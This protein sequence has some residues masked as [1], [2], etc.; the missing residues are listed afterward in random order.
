MVKRG[1]DEQR[2]EEEEDNGTDCREVWSS[3]G[4]GDGVFLPRLSFF[5]ENGLQTCGNNRL[6]DSPNPA[7]RRPRFGSHPGSAIA[8]ACS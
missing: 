8:A 3:A 6:Q 5:K 7:V 1:I 2:H 4:D